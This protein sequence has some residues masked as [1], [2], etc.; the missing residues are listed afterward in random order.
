[1]RV[2]HKAKKPK[3]KDHSSEISSTKRSRFKALRSAVKMATLRNQILPLFLLLILV[4]L[5]FLTYQVVFDD[6][7]FPRVYIGDVNISALNKPE[8]YQ[9]V[10]G[11]VEQRLSQ[12]IVFVHEGKDYTIDLAS[13]SASLNLSKALDYAYTIGHSGPLTER[14]IKQFKALFLSYRIAP[15]ASF[16]KEDQ[17]NSINSAV[18][19]SPQDASLIIE[20]PPV[21][22][23]ESGK[24]KI[25]EGKNGS[26]LDNNKI[27]QEIASFLIFGKYHNNLPITEVEPKITTNDVKKASALLEDNNQSPLKLSFENNNWIIDSKLLLSFLSL[28][29]AGPDILDQKKLEAFLVEVAKKIDQPVKEG[30][31]SFDPNTTKVSQFTASQDGR[32]LDRIKTA[33]L[34]TE[35]ITN[36]RSRE[37]QLP[38][39]IVKPKTQTSDV[40]ELGIK[41]LIGRG[42]SNFAGSI[43]NRIYNVGL[44]AAKINGT[45]IAPGQTF[46]FNQT[47]GDISAATGFKQAYVIKSGRTVLDDGGGICQVSTTLFRAALNTGLPIVERTAH[48]YRVGYYEQGFPPGLDAT[49]FYPSVDFKF[50]NDTTHH[51]LVQAYVSG[52]TLTVD[53]YG[54]SDGRTVSQSTPV[55]LSRTPALPEIR[56]D[57]PTLPVGEI[58]QVDFAAA[59]ANI[60]FKRTVTKDGQTLYDETFRSNYRPWAAVYLVGTK[61]D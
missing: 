23:T 40:N 7:F 48:A 1:M 16:P 49:I 53:L 43:P 4:V 59:G 12:K 36:L 56:Q 44:G 45:L 22:S 51:I 21:G 41:E 35:A 2:E 15:E 42:V 8:A 28:E 47:V 26:G 13:S 34:L 19:T 5:S 18:F 25:A 17:L 20:E 58:K 57:D 14:V 11:R 24:I 54:T 29:Q 3:Q 50:K 10:N 52:T 37:I 55:F 46:S 32:E 39:N 61:T 27:K 6:K 31:F 30:Q 9:L 38:V 60:S 33:S